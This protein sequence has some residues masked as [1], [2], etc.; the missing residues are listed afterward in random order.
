MV[1]TEEESQRFAG[2]REE[3]RAKLLGLRYKEDGSCR[4]VV[5]VDDNAV[6]DVLNKHFPSKADRE[7]YWAWVHDTD[8]ASRTLQQLYTPSDLFNTLVQTNF[9]ERKSLAVLYS[10]LRTARAPYIPVGCYNGYRYRLSPSL[11][12]LIVDLDDLDP[13]DTREFAIDP[14]M[15]LSLPPPRRIQYA[16]MS[17][18]RHARRKTDPS[19]ESHS[20]ESSGQSIKGRN[21]DQG[22]VFFQIGMLEGAPESEWLNNGRL[23]DGRIHTDL[24]WQPTEWVMVVVIDENNRA[25]AVW[26]LQDFNPLITDTMET[27]AIKEEE[28]DWGLLLGETDRKWM[29][30]GVKIANN[31]EDI[32]ETRAWTMDEYIQ[33]KYDLVQA[34][35]AE[36]GEGLGPLIVR[37]GPKPPA[38]LD[39]DMARM[40]LESDA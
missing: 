31:I 6:V 36:R 19:D 20:T 14:I 21:D 40:N 28:N 39:S 3:V 12:S 8:R 34:V 13:N 29:R 26:L 25:S 17:S 1:Y 27:Y 11:H 10:I 7:R 38:E 16:D 2:V 15:G 32:K 24:N 33:G 35:L 18:E 9:V 37:Q 5:L 22:F 30:G 4:D 23:R